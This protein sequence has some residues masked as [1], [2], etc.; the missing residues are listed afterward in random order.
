MRLVVALLFAAALASAQKFTGFDPTS[1]DRSVDPCV[2]FYQYAC[3]GWIAANPIPAD[4]SRWGRFSALAER[5][6]TVLQSI[7]EAD[8]TDKPTRSTVDREIGDYYAACMDMN[9]INSRGTAP[10]KDDLDRIYAMR[11]KNAITDVVVHLYRIGSTP[12][13]S[14]TS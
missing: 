6:R 7:L 5:N 4:Q 14:F 10:L 9:A 3:G 2:N 11:D 1:L 8:S 13:F 12:F